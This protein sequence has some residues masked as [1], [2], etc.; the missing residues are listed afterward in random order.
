MLCL[1][2]LRLSSSVSGVPEQ[3][4]IHNV[5]S[6]D[7][8]PVVS[9]VDGDSDFAQVFNPSWIEASAGTGGKAGLI[10][11]TQNCTAQPAGKCV[12]CSGVAGAASLLTFAE[13][14]ND[15][16][17]PTAKPLF[18]HIST[19]SAVFG[20]HDLTDDQ[21]TEDPRVVYDKKTGT[22]YMMYTCYNS[23]KT[24]QDKVTM[25]LATAKDPTTPGSWVRHGPIGFSQGSKSG[26]LLIRDEG[27]H[28][29]YWG[30]GKISIA[31]S[32]DLLSWE[33]GREF[34]NQTLWGNDKVEAG[35]PPMKLTTGDYIFFHNSWDGVHWPHGVGYQPAWVVLNGSD[36]SQIIAR[37]PAP[38]WS[39]GKEPWMAG[40]APYTCNVGNVSFLEAAHPV[41]GL[42]DTFR[43]YFGGADAVI[44]SAVVSFKQTGK[45]CDGGLGH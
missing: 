44:G 25:C 11:R 43:V 26:A 41:A 2:A 31:N 15:D 39:P 4:Y 1:V 37:A 45:P 7:P 3:C 21:G 38:L 13:L 9:A 12:A 23:G 22:Y 6:F 34:I 33:E 16:N 30:A 10:I 32:T 8:N 19:S 24:K 5:V 28:F 20:P 40:V 35:P 42:T 14:R 18:K 17:D 27:P 36:L 29:L